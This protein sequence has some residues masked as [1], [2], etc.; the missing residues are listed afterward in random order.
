MTEG[1]R[2]TYVHLQFV[3]VSVHMALALLL[4]SLWRGSMAW[5]VDDMGGCTW[6]TNGFLDG[7][8]KPERKEMRG[9]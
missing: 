2:R 3:E 5:Q 8:Q 4:L 7:S 6:W 9:S 1:K